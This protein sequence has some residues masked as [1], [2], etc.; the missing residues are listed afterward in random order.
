[1]IAVDEGI[2]RHRTAIRVL[3]VALGTPQA[4][5]GLWALVASR[6]FYDQ[7]PTGQG[8][9]AQIGP[10]DQ[11]LVIDFGALFVATGA[12]MLLAAAWMRRPLVVA[13]SV[14]WLL[15]AV[16]HTIWHLT[17]VG[18]PSG[19]ADQVA[20]VVTLLSTVAGPV[21]ILGLLRS[22]MG[23]SRAAAAPADGGA[24]V[25]GVRHSRNPI[26][27]Y[28]FRATRKL[29]GSTV[30]P[31]RVLAHH[32]L[33]LMGYGAFEQAT[34][35][36]NRV[37]FRLKALGEL[38]ASQLVGCEWCLDFGSALARAE[39]ITDDE[40]RDLLDY[41]ASDRFS[42]TEKLVLDYA[43]GMSRTP[44]EVP[45]ELFAQLREHFDDA[46]LVELTSVIALEN[47]RA[48]FNWAFGIEGE[49]FSQGAYCVR[50]TA[51]AAPRAPASSA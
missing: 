50:P 6:N 17:D 27:R 39:G 12:L 10:Y 7:F 45:D 31:I 37:P 18:E 13:A 8:W 2:T 23:V 41:R 28:S 38:K 44:V 32:P 47:Y 30:E 21:A 20:N 42:D 48:R 46:Q 3:L 4:A 34:D 29:V 25:P 33:L 49:G 14:A 24:R 22:R 36:A 19:T 11:H 43:A 9:I 5:I 15:Y 26:V 40:L 51:P 1:M 35:K 16:P